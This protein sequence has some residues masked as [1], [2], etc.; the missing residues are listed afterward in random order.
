MEPCGSRRMGPIKGP[1]PPT[2][3]MGGSINNGLNSLGAWTSYGTCTS[4]YKH[5][6]SSSL[7]MLLLFRNCL[8]HG[9]HY[10]FSIHQRLGLI[11]SNGSSFKLAFFSPENSTNRYL[12]I[13]YNKKSVLPA[14]WVANRDKP[15]KD[16]SG[17]LTI[18]EDWN[19]VLLNGLLKSA[20]CV[21][22]IATSPS[23]VVLGNQ[24]HL[25]I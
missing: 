16:S 3:N 22:W 7:A 17:V 12:E 18:S 15:L 9:H 24:I 19:L 6:S 4:K 23:Q 25:G 10:I 13:W 20:V 14:Q 11:I 8:C 21:A 2:P 1:D 5:V